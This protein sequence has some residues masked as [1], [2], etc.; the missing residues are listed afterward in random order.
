MYQTSNFDLA[1]SKILYAALSHIHLKQ[2]LKILN[3]ENMYKDSYIWSTS[4]IL[5]YYIKYWNKIY[6]RCA[7]RPWSRLISDV[8]V[9][10]FYDDIIFFSQGRT[11]FRYRLYI[12][13]YMIAVW[14]SH[15]SNHGWE[16]HTLNNGTCTYW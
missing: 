2:A 16:C 13:V 5:L 6:N 4:D 9:K 7:W 1:V 14:C 10:L 15:T 11:W 8:H 12:S 3:V